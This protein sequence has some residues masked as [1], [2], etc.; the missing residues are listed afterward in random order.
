MLRDVDGVREGVALAEEAL[1]EAPVVEL[2]RADAER[3]RDGAHEVAEGPRVE[4]PDLELDGAAALAHADEARLRGNRPR[5]R[6]ESIARG[7]RAALHEDTAEPH[8]LTIE[9]LSREMRSHHRDGLARAEGVARGVRRRAR[10]Q[11]VLRGAQPAPEL[12]VIRARRGD[13]DRVAGA[14]TEERDARGEPVP[15]KVRG[16][17]DARQVHQVP[18]RRVDPEIRVEHAR[19]R[20]DLLD[21]VDRRRRRDEQRVDA[22]PRRL[23]RLPQGVKSIRRGEHVLRLE[24]AGLEENVAHDRQQ[25]LRLSLEQLAPGEEPLDDPGAPVEHVP[26]FPKGPEVH[27]DQR[28]PHRAEAIHRLLEGDAGMVVA[29]ELE[30]LSR[31]DADPPRLSRVRR[32]EGDRLRVDPREGV[33]RIPALAGVG[34]GARVLHRQREDRH[35][36][37]R[38]AR[39]HHAARA[40]HTAGGLEADHVVEAPPERG[41]SPRCRSRARSSRDP[42][43]PRPPTPSSNPPGII[44]ASKGFVGVPYGERT[45][46]SPVAS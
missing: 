30:L 32:L 34:H 25:G 10:G 37:E 23:D 36:I 38:A 4:R 17:G 1:D 6:K 19:V 27:L 12:A 31:G 46:T 7:G 28:R 33:E 29:E 9:R 3:A 22:A 40:E 21:A 11:G 2:D 26:R 24:A 13:E 15:A 5:Q 42:R 41:R 44:R 14:R 35:A 18:E 8:E 20:E 16:H 45:P 43:R 39:R